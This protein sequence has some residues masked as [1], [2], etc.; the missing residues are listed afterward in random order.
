MEQ[1]QQQQAVQSKQ[2]QQTATAVATKKVIA[3]NKRLRE[4]IDELE[5]ENEMLRAF[6]GIGGKNEYSR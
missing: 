4:R 1:Q 6:V 5:H 3:E 2:Q